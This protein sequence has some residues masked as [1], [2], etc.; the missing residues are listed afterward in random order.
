MVFIIIL[1]FSHLAPFSSLNWKA[2]KKLII[3]IFI[4]K[5][6]LGEILKANM[7]PDCHKKLIMTLQTQIIL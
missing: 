1:K 6:C 2:K 3:R 4:H 5:T 7:I